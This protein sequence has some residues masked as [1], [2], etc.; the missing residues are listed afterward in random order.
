LTLI[1]IV[2]YCLC[3]SFVIEELENDEIQEGCLTTE[4]YTKLFSAYLYTNELCAA[5]FLWRR[6]PEAIKAD[7][8]LNKVWSIGKALWSKHYTQA[9]ELIDCKWSDILEPIMVA[10]KRRIQQDTL[11]FISMHYENIQLDKFQTFMGVDKEQAER[12]IESEGWTCKNGYV[13]PIA[14]SEP[15]LGL[16][17]SQEILD[18]LVTLSSFTSYI[19][20]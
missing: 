10:I 4:Q 2:N 20:N 19:E 17:G 1:T 5:K 8:E 11:K 12:I 9:Y 13:M 15:D 14:I 7:S 16:G 6:I 3:F 18:R